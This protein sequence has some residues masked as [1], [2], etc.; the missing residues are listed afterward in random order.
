MR[1]NHVIVVHKMNLINPA[2]IVVTI[3]VVIAVVALL[4]LLLLLIQFSASR[5]L[6][7][8]TFHSF[9]FIGKFDSIAIVLP[10]IW[11]FRVGRPLGTWLPENET[12][13]TV[14]L[15]NGSRKN[16]GNWRTTRPSEFPK[17]ASTLICFSTGCSRNNV[18]SMKIAKKTCSLV[19]ICI[20]HWTKVY[21]NVVWK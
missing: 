15:T 1:N 2:L 4:L 11:G 18:S 7:N 8:Y 21:W 9:S 17:F 19:R 14:W 16:T 5:F 12:T 6:R 10:S 3:I 20:F 13:F